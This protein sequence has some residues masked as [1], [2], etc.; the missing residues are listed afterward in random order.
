MKMVCVIQARMGSTRLPGK[1]LMDI[2]G[3]PMLAHVIERS[4]A[5]KAV[6]EVVVATTTLKEDEAVIATAREYGAETFAGDLSDVL[7]RYYQAARQFEADVVMRVTADCPLLDPTVGDHVVSHYEHGRVDYC[8]NV[9]PPTYPDG[10]NIEI[11]DFAALEKSWKVATLPSDR[12]H[13]TTY[14]RTHPEEFSVVNVESEEDMSD[15]RWTVDAPEDLDFVRQIFGHM[16]DSGDE[17]PGVSEVIGILDSHPE[18]AAFESGIR[19]HAGWERSLTADSE[20][21]SE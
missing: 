13:V 4:K 3:I 11:V 9:L 1:V 14:I 7:D 5:I 8:S 2:A 16:Q 19:R 12:E 20:L 15:L 17:I 6:D 18:L 10:V 21:G